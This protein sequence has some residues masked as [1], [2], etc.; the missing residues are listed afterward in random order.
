[1]FLSSTYAIDTDISEN[2]EYIAIA[3]VDYSGINI[4][5][6][7]EIISVE[8]AIS[9]KEKTVEN[10][11]EADIGKVILNINYQKNNTLFCMLD[12]RIISMTPSDTETLYTTDDS[13]KYLSP[14]TKNSYIR[15]DKESSGVLNSD[16]RLKITDMKDDEHVYVIEGNIKNMTNSEK[17]VALNYGKQINFI[18]LNGWLSKKFIST[19][20]IKDV[21]LSDKIA[22]IIYKNKI[23]IIKL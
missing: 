23:D 5:S 2:N 3:E 6:K 4:K 8:S 22:A 19:K 11:Y 14:E 20:E 12:D 7:V 21:K 10:T 13:T 17:I 16:Y 9:E 15:I 1:M 18:K